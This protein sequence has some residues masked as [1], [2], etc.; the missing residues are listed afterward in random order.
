MTTGA[1]LRQ[2]EG[3]NLLQ[4]APAAIY[5]AATCAHP[6][7]IGC[8]LRL[9]AIW[10]IV[11]VWLVTLRAI[12]LLREWVTHCVQGEQRHVQVGVVSGAWVGC[13]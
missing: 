8:F 1:A 7:S 3:C 6:V 2:E 11:R 5:E 10:L 12:V 13:Y 9:A 4:Q